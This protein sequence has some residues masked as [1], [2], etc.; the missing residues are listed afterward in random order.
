MVSSPTRL[1]VGLTAL[2]PIRCTGHI[3]LVSRE[4]FSHSSSGPAQMGPVENPLWPG[5]RGDRE[6]V[7]NGFAGFGN[8]FAG[9]G[10]VSRERIGF[11]SRA[12]GISVVV[13][14]TVGDEVPVAVEC[15]GDTAVDTVVELGGA[16]V[17]LEDLLS[18]Q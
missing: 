11:V 10:N 13:G 7:G 16:L 15:P 1:K 6:A 2:Q 9:F 8:G 18:L 12:V 14:G 4:L 3:R 17:V 5:H